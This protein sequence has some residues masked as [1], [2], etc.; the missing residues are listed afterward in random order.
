MEQSKFLKIV[1]I[2]L[3]LLNIATMG[4]LW[5]LQRQSPSRPP[6]GGRPGGVAE[7]L[8]KEL[9][10][11]DSESA[12]Y[13]KMRRKHHEDNMSYNDANRIMRDRLF[14]LLQKPETDSAI[15][16]TM[17]DSIAQVQKKIE[18]NTF[19]H[20]KEVRLLLTTDAQRKKFDEIIGDAIKQI[21]QHPTRR[22]G[23]GGPPPP[24]P[25]DG[26]PPDGPPPPPPNR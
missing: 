1:I 25:G 16:R 21:G 26:P 15:V 9:Q 10:L 19:Y 20:F 18:L 11:N 23:P 13:D 6:H 7:Y 2:I 12:Q 5:M 4:Y 17:A 24:P 3:L 22:E 14:A 8:T